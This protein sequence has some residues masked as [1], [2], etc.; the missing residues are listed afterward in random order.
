MRQDGANAERG[1]LAVALALLAAVC[2]FG[3]RFMWDTHPPDLSAIY[4][5]GWLFADGETGLIYAAPEG[6][7][8]GTP[9]DWEPFLHEIGGFRGEVLPYVYPPLWAAVVSPVAGV[10]DPVSFFRGA[11]VLVVGLFAASTLVAWRMCRDWAMPLWAWVM[12][13][14]A[15]LATSSMSYMALI[16]LQ[17]HVLVVFLV[18]LAFERLG[19]GAA[20]AAGICLGLAAALK[21]GPAALV[22][23]FV[24]EREWRALGAF[25]VTVAVCALASLVLAG[26]ALNLA[27][28]ES[29]TSAVAGTQITGVTFSAE[30]LLDGAA[31]LLG[32]IEPIDMGAR[33]VRVGET[34]FIVGLAG[35]LAMLALMIWAYRATAPL[36]RGR[37]IVARLFLLGLLVGLFGPLGWVFYYLPQMFLLPGLVGLLPGARGFR[38]AAF[39]A[40]FTSWPFVVVVGARLDGDFPQ[41]ALGA[42]VL[43]AL[44][45]LVTAGLRPRAARG[46]VPEGASASV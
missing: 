45:V 44:F 5:A 3:V 43:L 7:F 36:D 9:P 39:G 25:A 20:R 15:L 19:A 30:V 26:P 27:F 6:F 34:P 16:Q 4:M 29:V 21:L 18:L 12:L 14:A 31:A 8:G 41:A 11:S 2:V 10:V 32:L 46:A 1:R 17:P 33:N 37:R 40:V 42:A 38:V 13:G 24:A 35:K 23:V 22:L 28:V